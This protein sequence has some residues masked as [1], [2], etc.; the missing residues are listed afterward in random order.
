MMISL[1]DTLK[2]VRVEKGTVRLDDT[3]K[4]VKVEKGA[5]ANRK[6]G[7]NKDTTKSK[8]IAEDLNFKVNL[9]SK[10][11]FL[12]RRKTED[13]ENTTFKCSLMSRKKY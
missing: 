13:S 4:I 1:E 3:L 11:R 12:S 5:E 2:V 10:K 8:N 9:K 7:A 6:V